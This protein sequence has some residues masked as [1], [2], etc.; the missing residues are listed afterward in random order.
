MPDN[1]KRWLAIGGIASG[2]LVSS[3]IV[4]GLIG[5]VAVKGFIKA[6][7]LTKENEKDKAEREKT[8]KDLKE[9]ALAIIKCMDD[10]QRGPTNLDE[11]DSVADDHAAVD[12]VRKGEINVIW[13][14]AVLDDQPGRRK[15]V[16]AW[17]VQPAGDG[18]RLIARMDGNVQAVD[19]GEF[20]SLPKARTKSGK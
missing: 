9:V 13:D 17:A 19:D 14:A 3:C 15:T 12:R 20:Q 7:G 2:V 11:L 4:C 6:G 18:Q 1:S 16:L 5:Y 10:K 8:L